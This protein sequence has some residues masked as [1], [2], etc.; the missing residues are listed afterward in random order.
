MSLLCNIPL[1]NVFCKAYLVYIF[2]FGIAFADSKSTSDYALSQWVY[3]KIE[4]AR[5]SI[6]EEQFQTAERQLK[7]LIENSKLTSY[8]K[9]QSW[10]LIAYSYYLNKQTLKAIDAYQR[11]LSEPQL[12]PGLQ[13]STLKTLAQL[14]YGE[15]HYQR[16][17][18]MISMLE[19]QA[20]LDNNTQL[21][22]AYC[23][24]LLDRFVAAAQV[25]DKL[26]AHSDLAEENWLNLLQACYHQLGDYQKMAVTLEQLVG[27][28]PKVDYMLTLAA[29]YGQINRADKQLALLEAI[30]ES[31]QLG[32]E[33]DIMNLAALQ[34][35]SGVPFKAAKIIEQ[36]INKGYVVQNEK[37]TLQLAQSWIAAKEERFAIH[38]LEELFDHTDKNQS[39]KDGS[40]TISKACFLLGQLYFSRNSWQQ[41][42]DQLKVC[43]QTHSDNL[44]QIKLLLAIAYVNQGQFINA[45]SILAQLQRNERYRKQAVRWSQYVKREQSRLAVQ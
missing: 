30:W 39:L 4:S 34:L 7:N 2:G 25:L 27:Y 9:A 31:R 19:K 40:E 11:V 28:Y 17:L 41:A 20:L 38:T 32:D 43:K 21:L 14:H 16:S 37:H 15:G 5:A 6:D 12:S 24:Y 1:V 18:D 13:Q 29:I 35:Q 26:I 42:I 36:A 45:E 33:T 23:L 8:E 44:N 3:Q 10:N 22:K